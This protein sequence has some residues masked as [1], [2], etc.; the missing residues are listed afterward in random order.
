MK[1]GYWFLMIV[2]SWIVVLK[3]LVMILKNFWLLSSAEIIFYVLL[4]IG[5]MYLLIYSL[6][7][8]SVWLFSGV[9]PNSNRFPTDIIDF[10]FQFSGITL[11]RYF[12]SWLM[13][14]LT[15]K[16]CSKTHCVCLS[17]FICGNNFVDATYFFLFHRN[18]CSLWIT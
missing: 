17:L 16:I 18:T 4:I 5:L 2:Y 3:F 15:M 8:F 13:L 10:V 7:I 1:H 6:A 11:H 9:Q 12:L 14:V